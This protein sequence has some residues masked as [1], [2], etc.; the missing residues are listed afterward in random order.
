M[1]AKRRT[2]PPGPWQLAGLIVLLVLCSTRFAWGAL[3]RGD[4][5]E[6][7]EYVLYQAGTL[8]FNYF[9]FGAVRRGLGG[10]IVHLLGPDTLFSTVAYHLLSATAVAGVAARV[11]QRMPRDGIERALFALAIVAF[12]LRWGDD[13]G[14]TDLSVVALL[15]GAAIAMRSGRAVLA[16][17]LVS[18]GLFIHESSYVFGLPLLAALAWQQGG[19]RAFDTPTRIRVALV[20]ALTLGLYLGMGRLPHADTAAMVQAVR[21]KLPPHIHVEWAMYFALSGMRGVQTSL[22]QNATDPSY[23]VHPVSGLVLLALTWLLLN[24][25]RRAG[26]G[27]ALLAALPGYTFLCVVANDASRWALFALFNVWLISAAL[28]SPS[29]SRAPATRWR[30]LGMLALT[31]GWAVLVLAKPGSITY[32]VYAPSPALEYAVRQLGGP[33]TPSIEEAL[34]RCDPDWQSVLGGPAPN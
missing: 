18:V 7:R 2:A 26:L 6:M 20:F 33:R 15:G 5:S 10:S 28:P 17:V 27:P 21:A 34:A 11:Y 29:T 4:A 12:M 14:R 8:A 30:R 23:W 9:E 13:A 25:R 32:R 1:L 19:P 3:L 22:C 24:G 31:Y 16:V